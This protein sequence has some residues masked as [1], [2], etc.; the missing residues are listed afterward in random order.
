MSPRKNYNQMYKEEN[1]TRSKK[2]LKESVYEKVEEPV[3]EEKILDEVKEDDVMEKVKKVR[4]KKK[5][6]VVVNGTLNVRSAPNGDI[7]GSIPSGE[8]IEILDEQD[9][10][11]KIDRGFVMSKFVEVK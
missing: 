7:V 10:W 5:E 8:V 6:G 3:K 2:E 11:Y 1:D 9:G 4:K